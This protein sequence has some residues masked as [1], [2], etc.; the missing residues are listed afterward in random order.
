MATM[1]SSSPLLELP[2]EL[3][4]EVYDYVASEPLT[5]AVVFHDKRIPHPLARTCKLL[6]AEFLPIYE[7]IDYSQIERL[8]VVVTDFDFHPFSLFWWSVARA[9]PAPIR[10]DV[11]VV[12][13]LTEPEAQ[14]LDGLVSW[15][16]RCACVP[17]RSYSVVFDWS[18]YDPDSA[19]FR[20]ELA[21]EC[22]GSR[23]RRDFDQI[24]V[25]MF[26][27]Q[28]ARQK[29][30]ERPYWAWDRDE[31]E[32]EVDVVKQKIE[33]LQREVA[34]GKKRAEE[35]KA[36]RAGIKRVKGQLFKLQGGLQHMAK[37]KTV[38]GRT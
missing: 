24:C 31:L 20:D 8:T 30:V 6:R 21:L 10:A 9:T 23:Y 5:D 33:R 32:K 3:R 28:C 29:Q 38:S 14:D 34:D 11:H 26:K 15:L 22:R 2:P 13:N 7:L 1:G 27:A 16:S 36:L 17:L 4:N 37:R 35:V 25:A 18:T 12:L 19:K